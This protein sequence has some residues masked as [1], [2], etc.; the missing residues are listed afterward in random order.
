MDVQSEHDYNIL[1]VM[2]KRPS[3]GLLKDSFVPR[4]TTTDPISATHTTIGSFATAQTCRK[5]ESSHVLQGQDLSSYHTYTPP[6]T[7]RKFH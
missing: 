6:H 7:H 5:R 1:S 4:K 3:L 2:G